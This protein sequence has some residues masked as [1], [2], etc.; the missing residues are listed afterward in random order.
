MRHVWLYLLFK[1]FIYVCW[2]RSVCFFG[3]INGHLVNCIMVEWKL[4]STEYYKIFAKILSA[5]FILCQH[6]TVVAIALHEYLWRGGGVVTYTHI[7]WHARFW[8]TWLSHECSFMWSFWIEFC[9][10]DKMQFKWLSY[11]KND[12]K[13]NWIMLF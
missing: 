7:S 5:A 13:V 12:I 4:I 10:Q 6:S 1:N 11:R 2:L 8:L 9:G 3:Y